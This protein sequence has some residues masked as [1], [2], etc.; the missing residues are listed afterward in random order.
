[1]TPEDR[2]YIT[3]MMKDVKDTASRISSPNPGDLVE[4]D[5]IALNF[6][7]IADAITKIVEE[8]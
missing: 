5:A 3:N 7:R 6:Y 1:M 4:L 8:E 2:V